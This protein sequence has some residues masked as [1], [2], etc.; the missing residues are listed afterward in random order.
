MVVMP[1][2]ESEHKDC[3]PDDWLS[4]CVDFG[5]V[6]IKWAHDRGKCGK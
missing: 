2:F 1:L 3:Q 4:G 5:I 6:F